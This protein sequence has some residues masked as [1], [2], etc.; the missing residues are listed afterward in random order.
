MNIEDLSKCQCEAPGFCPIFNKEMGTD[1]PNW[2]W[3]QGC[4]VERRKK[5]LETTSKENRV[6][7]QAKD[8][9]KVSIVS[10]YDEILPP[11]SKFAVCVIPANELASRL[12]DI[13]RKSIQDYANRCEADYIELSGDQHPDWPMANKWRVHKVAKTYKKTLYLD[14]DIVISDV[15]PN[16]FKVTPDDKISAYDEYEDFKGNQRWINDQQEAIFHELG[17]RGGY[18]YQSL[19]NGKYQADRMLNGGVL[20]IPNS[21][22]SHYQQ[23]TEPYDRVWCFDQNYLTLTLPDRLL[24]KLDPTWNFEYARKD[25]YDKYQSAHF[26]HINDLRT[27]VDKRINL[28]YILSKG[29]ELYN[30]QETESKLLFTKGDDKGITWGDPV[31][32]NDEIVATKNKRRAVCVINASEF[33]G[34]QL[35][36]TRPAIRAYAKRC[37]ADYV[38][39]TG[40][41][42]PE[43]PM[44]NKFRLHSVTKAYEKTLYLDCDI[45]I[46]TDIN[47]PN[48]FEETPDDRVSAMCEDRFL[49]RHLADYVQGETKY[50]KDEFL[51]IRD[52]K[53]ENLLNGG[54]LVIPR[55]LADNYKQPD[56][57]YPQTWCFDQILLSVT[58]GNEL[59][60][61]L[62][63]KWNYSL[64]H[65]GFAKDC[66]S[67]YFKHI[68]SPYSTRLQSLN[69]HST[70]NVRGIAT[71]FGCLPTKECSHQRSGWN[72]IC[73]ELKGIN[74]DKGIYLDATLENSFQWK[75]E[76][77][78]HNG[79]IPYLF[80][81]AGFFHNPPNTPS[82]Y[83]K[84]S[85]HFIGDMEDTISSKQFVLSMDY[86]VS[87]LTL[88]PYLAKFLEDRLEVPV[89]AINVSK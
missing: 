61:I 47:I 63:H 42:F 86:C 88:S 23:P 28:L 30:E 64:K 81:W 1:P 32:F 2:Q 67:A 27:E 62:D 11:K 52:G 38:E 39:L 24:N 5:Y 60:N 41:Q 77:Y 16:I 9:S 3:C 89:R 43:Y 74:S 68:N 51:Q 56:K 73:Q 87:L 21:L 69:W 40:D 26:L 4:G 70:K 53:K 22:A 78:E 31:V 18:S 14:C 65:V 75:Y 6:I 54:V 17:K 82:F 71:S 33:T 49:P 79:H 45:V 46:N 85:K 12:L 48:I 83:E 37:E 29:Q 58:I 7:K 36:I 44:Y 55:C 34:R 13:T 72:I 10:F 80:P 76:L 20:V 57:K 19:E 50:I 59:L 25:F 66:E 84:R 15:A 35:E 8:K